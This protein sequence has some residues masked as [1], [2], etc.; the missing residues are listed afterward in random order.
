MTKLVFISDTHGYHGHA[1]IIPCDILVHAG[2]FSNDIGQSAMR[3]FCR[4][5]ELQPAKHKILIGGNHD[6]QLEIWP[7]PSRLM[8][9]ELCPSCTYLQDS[10]VTLMG[11]KFWG[12]PYT[13][14]FCDW[15]FNEDRGFDI[16]RHW[17]LIPDD[18]D[19]LVTHGPPNDILDKSI[20]GERCGCSDL[21]RAL[22]RVKPKVHAFGH[23][24]YSYGKVNLW[25][26]DHEMTELLNCSFV[27]EDYKP[28]NLPHV[29]EL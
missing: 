8:I 11:I 12:S 6:R 22:D 19:V 9:Q 10:G 26:N 4:W 25:Y 5:L 17:D 7:S 14:R 29:L 20:T 1:R 3:D 28:K 27:N 2:D 23:I 21:R 15:A 18:T 16:K 13:P 24:H